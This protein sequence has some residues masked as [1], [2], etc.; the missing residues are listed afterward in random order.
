M[1][2]VPLK[3]FTYSLAALGACI[4][5]A[6]TAP[7]GA[8]SAHPVQGAI[9]QPTRHT[10]QSATSLHA[11]RRVNIEFG[12]P[13]LLTEASQ[14]PCEIGAPLSDCIARFTRND[15]NEKPGQRAP[16]AATARGGARAPNTN[17]PGPVWVCGNWEMLWQGR[18]E[19]RSCEWR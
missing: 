12:E 1:Q 6:L 14:P 18:G 8:A 9:A 11:P 10:A 15:P 16:D 5:V 3:P 17:T 2:N 4:A 7:F 19:A 13:I